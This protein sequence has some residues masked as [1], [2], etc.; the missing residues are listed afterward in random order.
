MNI[1]ILL[2]EKEFLFVILAHLSH[3]ENRDYSL[4]YTQIMII[5]FNILDNFIHLS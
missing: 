4:L 5:I 2:L 3:R 1:I